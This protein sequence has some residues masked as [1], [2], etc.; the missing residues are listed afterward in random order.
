MISYSF[1]LSQ[2]WINKRVIKLV[3]SGSNIMFP[4]LTS[5]S[6]LYPAAEDTI[7]ANVS[8]GKKHAV[9][10]GVLKI[11][12]EH[13]EKINKGISIENI[14]YLNDMRWHREIYK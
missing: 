10:I 4:G 14:H 2:Q 5:G 3:L 8:E 12:A 11:Y 9:C 1:I 6:K 7:V 13:F